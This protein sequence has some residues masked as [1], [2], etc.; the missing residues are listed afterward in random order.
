MIFVTYS[1]G[2]SVL[3]DSIFVA[4]LEEHLVELVDELAVS[5]QTTGWACLIPYNQVTHFSLS[6]VHSKSANA[7]TELQQRERISELAN[8][9]AFD[10]EWSDLISVD[11]Q[12]GRLTAASPTVPFLN[13]S[14]SRKNSWMRIPSLA[15]RA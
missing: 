6:K 5:N 7:S 8:Y 12:E 10:Q 9:H 1:C 13:L 15:I 11:G 14:K 4:C 2:S 3:D